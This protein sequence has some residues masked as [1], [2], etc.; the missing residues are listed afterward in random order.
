[1]HV[2]E[3]NVGRTR[4][5]RRAT[6]F[7]ARK[8]HLS[9]ALSVLKKKKEGSE[10]NGFLGEPAAPL[11]SERSRIKVDRQTHLFISLSYR[12]SVALWSHSYVIGKFKRY[13][14]WNLMI[15][16]SSIHYIYILEFIRI[17]KQNIWLVLWIA[18]KREIK[19]IYLSMKKVLCRVQNSSFISLISIKK[20]LRKDTVLK[21]IYAII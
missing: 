9:L 7:A 17:C 5:S 15:I 16:I 11:Y 14:R 10:G 6:K 4:F 8:A 2:C 18:N 12:A 20:S 13:R 1:M 19:N 21:K 3:E